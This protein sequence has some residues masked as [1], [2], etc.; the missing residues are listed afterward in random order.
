MR[1]KP[2]LIMGLPGA[3]KTTLAKVLAP[4]LGAV[5]F[6][7]DA[8]RTNINKDLDFSV[9]SRIEQARRMRWLCDQVVEAGHPAIADFICP[10]ATTRDA[11]G[12]DDCF[13]V[14]VDRITSS[15]YPDT[16]KLF[17][18][19]ARYDVRVEA[20]GR[21]EYWAEVVARAYA[22]VF[23]PRQP[24]ALFVGRYQP[25]H[26]GHKALIEQGLARVGQVCIAVRDVHD[27][28][29]QNP[30]SFEDVK[31]RIEAAMAPYRGR[32]VVVPVPNISHIFYG[33]DVGYKIERI[34]L[35]A[36]LQGISATEFRRNAGLVGSG[37]GRARTA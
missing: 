4:R 30:L 26:D 5:L 6:N 35:D 31:Q 37:Q 12:E 34:D 33:R 19:P 11:F 32:Y 15:R 10:T 27:V 21:P 3:G 18:K 1:V 29:D 7:N 28:N 14:W 23:D 25:F 22:P 8:L 9:E 36:Q 24:T 16:D 2:I 17:E 13:V 20:E